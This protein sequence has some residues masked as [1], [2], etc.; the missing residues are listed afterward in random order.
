MPGKFLYQR[1]D[2][3]SQ[4]DVKMVVQSL[5]RNHL[6]Q[7]FEYRWVHMVPEIYIHVPDLVLPQLFNRAQVHQPAFLD[8]AYAVAD[9]LNLRKDMR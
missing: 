3:A 7:R 4:G 9:P 5:H 6:G 8:D 1:I 2:I